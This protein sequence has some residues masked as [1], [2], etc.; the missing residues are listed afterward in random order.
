MINVGRVVIAGLA[1]GVV[2]NVFD[3]AINEYLLVEEMAA[4]AQRLGLRAGPETLYVWAGIDFVYGLL[5]A[6]TYAAIRP[7][8]GPGPKTAIIAGSV[9][10]AAITIILGGFMTMGMFMQDVFIKSAALSYVSTL[11]ASLTAGALY[12]E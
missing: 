12:R 6:F 1:A 3:F 7:R 10:F 5:I 11:A 2:A 9:L 8:F 4:N